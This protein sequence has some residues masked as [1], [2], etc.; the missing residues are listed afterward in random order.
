MA[1]MEPRR[2]FSL[3]ATAAVKFEMIPYTGTR[4]LYASMVPTEPGAFTVIN[5]AERLGI[6]LTKDVVHIT[7]CYSKEHVVHLDAL[8][9]YTTDD[10][11]SAVCNEVKHWKGHKGQTCI[12]LGLISE[13]ITLLNAELQAAGALH[14]F[15]PYSP[16]ISL[17]DEVEVDPDMQLQIDTINKE[18][19]RSPLKL[20]FTNYSVG[21]QDD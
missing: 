16:H 3:T 19:S 5:I 2:S 4:G 9:A 8:P 15:T 21:D 13:S 14:S 18:L 10:T 20:T 1:P 11:F 6:K 7:V 12:V 17:S